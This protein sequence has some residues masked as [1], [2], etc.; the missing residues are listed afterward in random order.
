MHNMDRKNIIQQ[1]EKVLEEFKKYSLTLQNVSTNT[2]KMRTVCEKI[3]NSWSGSCFGYHS[4]LYYGNFEKP[5]RDEQFSVEWA[6]S[7]VFRNTGRK[8]LLM[9]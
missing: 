5:P 8:E 3:K 1:L 2:I 4:R 6:E 7:T 9:K